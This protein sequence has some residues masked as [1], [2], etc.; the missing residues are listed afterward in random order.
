MGM[1]DIGA[2]QSEFFSR[3]AF[4]MRAFRQNACRRTDD[5]LIKPTRSQPLCEL[6]QGFLP[7]PPGVARVNVNDGERSQKN[8]FSTSVPYPYPYAVL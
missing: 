1:D 7:A 5:G 6:Q 4:G 3:E 8:D 2:A